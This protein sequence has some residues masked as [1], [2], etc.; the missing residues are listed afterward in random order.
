MFY[1]LNIL[2]HRKERMKQGPPINQKLNPMW[3]NQMC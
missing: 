2:D 1:S 3:I